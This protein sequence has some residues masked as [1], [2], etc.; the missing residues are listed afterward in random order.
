MGSCGAS[1]FWCFWRSA[2][3]G[4]VRGRDLLTRGPFHSLFLAAVLAQL[5]RFHCFAFTVHTV[6]VSRIRADAFGHWDASRHLVQHD[7]CQATTAS[8]IAVV[9]SA[10]PRK[11][12]AKAILASAAFLAGYLHR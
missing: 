6:A 2:R 4:S 8:T 5:S 12:L 1:L 3:F 9:R 10:P 11:R 7:A